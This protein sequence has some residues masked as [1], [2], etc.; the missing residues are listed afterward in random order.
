MCGIFGDLVG[1]V[2]FKDPFKMGVGNGDILFR[3]HAESV[4]EERRG[5]LTSKKDRQNRT[6]PYACCFKISSQNK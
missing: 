2:V 5:H 1:E 3:V 6:G 4:I